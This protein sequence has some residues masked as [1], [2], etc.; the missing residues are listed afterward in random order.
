VCLAAMQFNSWAFKYVP[1]H[2]KDKM[3]E[4]YLKNILPKR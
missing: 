2:L 4:K 3:K 1:E